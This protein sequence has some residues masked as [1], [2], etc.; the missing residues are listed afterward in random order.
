MTK[1]TLRQSEEFCFKK[2]GGKSLQCSS[3]VDLDTSSLESVHFPPLN[4]ILHLIL[5]NFIV[6]IL[7]FLET[8]A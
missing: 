5:R 6:I 3:M 4:M 2:P 1:D 8:L 7:Y